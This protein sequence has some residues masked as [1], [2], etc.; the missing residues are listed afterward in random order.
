MALAAPIGN[1]T[2][3]EVASIFGEITGTE[4][5]K[6][7]FG[8]YD[9]LACQKSQSKRKSS[10][11]SRMSKCNVCFNI[12]QLMSIHAFDFSALM[13]NNAFTHRL[14]FLRKQLRS[15]NEKASWSSVSKLTMA[16]SSQTAF[17]IVGA[18]CNRSLERRHNNSAFATS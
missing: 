11:S 12:L 7:F 15:S 4:Q 10:R 18:I 5:S 14:I 9:G 6:A 16:L 13:K 17:Q 8:V 2:K 3:A 1:M